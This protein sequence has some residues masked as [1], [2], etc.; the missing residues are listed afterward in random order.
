MINS[1]DFWESERSSCLL[2][3][4]GVESEEALA[5]LIPKVKRLLVIQNESET[6]KPEGETA[7]AEP[8]SCF[9]GLANCFMSILSDISQEQPTKAEVEAPRYPVPEEVARIFALDAERTF[10]TASNRQKLCRILEK[11]YERIGDYHQGQGFVIAFLSLFLEPWE[12][13]SLVQKLHTNYLKGYFSC[14]PFTYIRDARVL[15]LLLKEV[16]AELYEHLDQLLVPETFVSKW[17]IALNIHVLSFPYVVEFIAQLLAEGETYLFKYGLKFLLHF[18]EE[19]L[20][21]S[22]VSLILAILRLDKSV[23]PTTEYERNVVYGEILRGDVEGVEGLGKRVEELRGMLAEELRQSLERKEADYSDDEIVFSDEEAE[24]EDVPTPEA[25]PEAEEESPL[26]AEAE[27][28]AT[29]EADVEA[30]PEPDAEGE[31]QK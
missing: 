24:A 27:E 29:P 17:F 31:A 23:L 25:E 2:N 10:K 12:V 18:R 30:T 21:T 5:K 20:N 4:S 3:R 26:S 8:K 13:I 11:T 16:D 7:D 15:F 6:S 19:I 14:Q 28:L 9:S 1:V 22:D